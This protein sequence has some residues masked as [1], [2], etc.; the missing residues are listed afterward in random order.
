MAGSVV[1]TD[2]DRNATLLPTSGIRT[3]VPAHRFV[4]KPRSGS[5][6]LQQYPVQLRA[7]FLYAKLQIAPKL[8]RGQRPKHQLHDHVS[9][10][11]HTP[12]THMKHDMR[13]AIRFAR[14]DQAPI[15]AAP[16][17]GRPTQRAG[18]PCGRHVR[19]RE[20]RRGGTALERIRGAICVSAS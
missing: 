12:K 8:M 3:L 14:A 11:T 17:Q 9:L 4:A 7:A 6:L 1:V 13:R 19:G 10:A 16:R 20:A 18:L 15:M 2:S 5:P